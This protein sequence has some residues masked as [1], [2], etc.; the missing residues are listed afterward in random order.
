MERTVE[1]YRISGTTSADVEVVNAFLGHLE[2]RAFAAHHLREQTAAVLGQEPLHR[3]CS[4]EMA[5]P[6]GGV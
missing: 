5:T 1:G 4:H 6:R 3:A 2:V